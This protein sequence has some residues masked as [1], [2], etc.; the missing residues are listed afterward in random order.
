MKSFP[1]KYCPGFLGLITF[2][3]RALCLKQL[4]ELTFIRLKVRQLLESK[5]LTQ[6]LKQD[7]SMFLS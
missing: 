6:R 4:K 5:P 1:V 7:K 2:G 3:V